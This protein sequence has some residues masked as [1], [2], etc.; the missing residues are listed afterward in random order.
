MPH[1]LLSTEFGFCHRTKQDRTDTSTASSVAKYRLWVANRRVSFQTRSMGA[2]CGLYGGKN[3]N[4]STLRYLCSNGASNLAWWY[5]ALSRMI[6]MRLPCVRLRSS[7][8]RN[9]SNVWASNVVH[10]LYANLPVTRLTAPKQAMD[11]RVGACFSNAAG[12]LFRLGTARVTKKGLAI[13]VW[14]LP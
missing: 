3:T 5:L 6:T 1:S 7:N 13:H 4:V 14:T 11:L 2:S 9:A 12:R 8:L 10:K